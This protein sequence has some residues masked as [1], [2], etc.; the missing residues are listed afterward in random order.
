MVCGVRGPE[1]V[2]GWSSEAG[3]VGGLDQGV[4]GVSRDV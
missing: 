3:C 4:L 1:R 2:C